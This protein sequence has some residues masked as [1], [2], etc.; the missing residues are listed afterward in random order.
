MSTG[1][2]KYREEKV[3]KIIK[4]GD[5]SNKHAPPMP[6]YLRSLHEEG[7]LDCKEVLNSNL[8]LDGETHKAGVKHREDRFCVPGLMMM[9]CPG[10][11]KRRNGD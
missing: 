3:W 9:P 1:K 4:K 6:A 2:R 8:A 10:I 7:I 11:L 5:L